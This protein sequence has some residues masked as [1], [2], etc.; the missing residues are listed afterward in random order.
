MTNE[1]VLS[2][3][4]FPWAALI[5][6]CTGLIGALGGAILANKFAEKRW[7]N[8]IKHE[9]SNEK[10]KILRE[11][12]EELYV[13][14]GRWSK[15]IFLVQLAQIKYVKSNRDWSGYQ[16]HVSQLDFE[17]GAHDRLLT[18]LELY[19]TELK[20]LMDQVSS[21]IQTS[22]SLHE[23]FKRGLEADIGSVSNSINK[24]SI[25]VE[26]KIKEMQTLIRE[27]LKPMTT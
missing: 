15:L 13:L 12:G 3:Y 24:A 6:A 11:K 23:N 21:H 27:R 19:F 20:S 14:L 2:A 22:N 16:D 5:T 25:D 17:P 10:A 18:L 8:Q 9:T 7:L 1:T 4:Q 26:L